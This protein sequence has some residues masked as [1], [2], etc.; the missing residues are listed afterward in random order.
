[1]RLLLYPFALIY[2]AVVRCRNFFFNIGLL[3]AHS[4]SVPIILAGNLTT[5]G[6]GKTPCIEYLARLLKK[7]Y[8]IAILSRG[9]K[10]KTS[11][12]IVSNASSTAREIGDEA[13]QMSMKHPDITIAVDKTRVHGIRK[14]LQEPIPP[15]CILLD[16]GYQHRWVQPGLSILLTEYNALFTH[17]YLLPAGNLR[18][19]RNNYRRADIILI[20]KSPAVHS[21]ISEKLIIKKMNPSQNQLVFFS[22]L[23]HGE[24]V[25]IFPSSHPNKECAKP[26]TIVLFTGIANPSSLEQHLMTKCTELITIKF[27]DHHQYSHK[28][29]QRII[30]IFNNQF[31]KNKILITTEKDLARLKGEK[32]FESLSKFPVFYIPVSMKIHPHNRGINFDQVIQDYVRTNKK[33]FSLGF[34]KTSSET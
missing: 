20:T 14:L 30:N 7:Q 11:D 23:A 2:G 9:Y 33:N 4:F 5:G 22:Y 29:I 26:H 8:R 18:E 32:S 1:M 3:K 28:D 21:P 27:Q 16:D 25:P 6:T 34:R 19:H 12:F 13:K 15:D 31:T 10:R 17:D 24:R